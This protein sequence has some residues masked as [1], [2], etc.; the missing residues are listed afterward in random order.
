MA[1]RAEVY[2]AIDSERAYQRTVWFDYLEN[3]TEHDNPLEIGEFLTLLA[4][5]V[6][7][8]Q[9]AWTVEKKMEMEALARIRKIAAIAVNC[10]EQNGAPHRK[11]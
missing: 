5:Y 3:D 1:D 9:D 4:V 6:R 11:E 10:M 7:K 2:A 8:A